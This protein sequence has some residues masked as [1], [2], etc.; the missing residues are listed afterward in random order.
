MRELVMKRSE[1][2]IVIAALSAAGGLAHGAESSQARMQAAFG[3]SIAASAMPPQQMTRDG[4]IDR[5]RNEAVDA[6]GLKHPVTPAAM[7]EREAQ[8]LPAS[9]I[10]GAD[11]PAFNHSLALIARYDAPAQR[12]AARAAPA[13]GPDAADAGPSGNVSGPPPS[14]PGM[15]SRGRPADSLL[16]QREDQFWT[17]E[18]SREES[19]LALR[20]PDL[21]QARP[22]PGLVA[23]EA[24]A[25]TASSLP[26]PP[27]NPPR[28]VHID[29]VQAQRE[30]GPAVLRDVEISL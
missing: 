2:C 15:P 13:H 7:T 14:E 28:P 5:L 4:A 22:E 26:L 23:V 6:L 12:H 17:G 21:E 19:S 11:S 24:G 1:L 16:A 20:Q 18:S 27:D 9:L 25:G 3:F 10:G 29:P 8:G 30:P